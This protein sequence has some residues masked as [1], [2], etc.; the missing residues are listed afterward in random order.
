M[1]L[2]RKM[3]RRHRPQLVKN[4]NSVAMAIAASILIFCLSLPTTA[5]VFGSHRNRNSCRQ[6]QRQRHVQEPPRG[7]S[8]GPTL[9]TITSSSTSTTSSTTAT[10]STLSKLN[11]MNNYLDFDNTGESGI[12]DGNNHQQQ[13]RLPIVAGNWKLNPSTVQEATT[14]L[15]L[16]AANFL[17]HRSSFDG[18]APEVVVFPPTPYLERAVTL[19]EGTGIQVG[20]QTVGTEPKGAFTGEVSPSMV[21]SLGCSYVLV[22]HSERRTL[23]GETDE[24]INAKIKLALQEDADYPAQEKAH[25]PPGPSDRGFVQTLLLTLLRLEF[26]SWTGSQTMKFMVTTTSRAGGSAL[27]NHRVI[28]IGLFG[29]KSLRPLLL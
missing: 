9:K 25:Q 26:L 16:L 10:T 4:S 24:L 5:L 11:S 28:I 18:A 22:G 15:K 20:A 13:Q 21:R 17:H 19:L 3:A 12:Y 6:Y 23:Y 27:V 2:P 14:L 1:V 7:N 8:H 29:E